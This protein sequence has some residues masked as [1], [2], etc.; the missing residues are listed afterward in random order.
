MYAGGMRALAT[1]AIVTTL[2]CGMGLP[3]G[4]RAR[5]LTR[6]SR[7]HASVVESFTEVRYP[8][9]AVPEGTSIS[10]QV[11]RYAA[12]YIPNAALADGR[13]TH[14][15]THW[16]LRFD[17]DLVPMSGGGCQV[18]RLD[19]IVKLVV[20]LPELP[21]QTGRERE[22]ERYL[23]ALEAHEAGHVRIVRDVTAER[24]RELP[25][26]PDDGNCRDLQRHLAEALEEIRE[27]V[28]VENR[29]YDEITDHGRAPPEVWFD[30]KGGASAGSVQP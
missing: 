29:R 30:G 7:P 11:S 15:L 4:E 17:H 16:R 27:A 9:P 1:I 6:A 13:I 12:D 18:R 19:L 2:G 3:S 20:M 25:D 5:E 14:G 22:R 28:R 8:V 10:E 24:V 26:L 23:G 21:E